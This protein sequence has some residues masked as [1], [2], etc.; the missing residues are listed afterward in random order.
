MRICLYTETAL[1]KIG[2]QEMVVDALARQF[3]ALG[4]DVVVL[5]PHPRLPLRANDAALPYP[6]VRHPRFFSTRFLVSWYRWFLTR[7]QRKRPFDV[8]HCHGLYPSGYL[9]A[10]SKQQ[11]GVPI[12]LTSHGGDVH[13]DNVRLAKPTLR[14]RHIEALRG[15]DRLVA[16]SRFTEEGFRWLCP[17]QQ[18][19]VNIPNGVELHRFVSSLP[20]PANAPP[21][22]SAG[23]YFLFLGRLK[24]RKGIDL[25]VQ[26]MTANVGLPLVVAGAG[27]ERDNLEELYRRLKLQDRVFF[28]GHVEYPAKA[29]WLQNAYCT[30]APS[31][32]WEAFAL[33]VMESYAA[34]TPIIVT[35]L[36]GFVDLVEEG[37]T[38]LIV[39]PESS[40]ALANAM[41]R[42][43]ADRVWAKRMGQ[44]CRVVAQSYGWET[45][46]R[47]HIELYTQ[48][49]EGKRVARAG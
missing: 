22:I 45:I 23:E 28:I 33:V 44:R 19:I 10:V 15:A 14:K 49:C 2:G 42:V 26:A 21:G 25:L 38:G 37:E 48:L 13:V 17:E 11:L 34:G 1:P 30:V 47:R 16:I 43:A 6:V 18:N 36:P 4:H 29:A 3:L 5:A 7:L 39:P 24:H 9:A 41:Q 46:A 35:D 8:L 32:S 40:T 27:E 20:L 31:R 12:V